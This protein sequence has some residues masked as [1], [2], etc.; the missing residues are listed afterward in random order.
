M[1]FYRV[2][3]VLAPE[4]LRVALDAKDWCVLDALLDDPRQPMSSIA[5]ACGLSRQSA[6][7]RIRKLEDAKL[8]P[9]YRTI[10]NIRKLGYASY[11]VFINLHDPAHEELLRERAQKSPW[12]NAVI[13]YDGIYGFEI[14]IMARSAAEFTT[15]YHDLINGIRIIDDEPLIILE[16]V[17][18]DTL[19]KKFIKKRAVHRHDAVPAKVIEY[20]PDAS[21]MR[22]MK[23]L[24]DDASLTKTALAKHVGLS[25]DAVAYRLKKL[26]ASKHIVQFRPIINYDVLGLSIQGVLLKV[27]YASERYKEFDA[28]QR[29]TDGII[30]SAKTFGTFDYIIYVLT[31]NVGEFHD[32]FRE[33][34][35]RFGDIIERY[36]L[37]YAH[38]QYKYTFMA[39]IIAQPPSTPR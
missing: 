29:G 10:I 12:V 22:I 3:R 35:R 31:R 33:V 34:K 6:E 14:S 23:L 11:H 8:I 17:K 37:L 1:R 38:T 24:A 9:G 5:N 7:Y 30:W 16:T 21:D 15:H 20:A 36:E 4:A 2:M 28:F 39:D 32:L 19:P 18:A 13:T 25:N 26:M 27:N